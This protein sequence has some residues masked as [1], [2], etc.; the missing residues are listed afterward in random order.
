MPGKD[1][2][3]LL[4]CTFA[5]VCVAEQTA[6]DL[7]QELTVLHRPVFHNPQHLDDQYSFHMSIL[8]MKLLEGIEAKIPEWEG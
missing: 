7:W 6:A 3:L 2:V 1:M 4:W 8:C 5:G